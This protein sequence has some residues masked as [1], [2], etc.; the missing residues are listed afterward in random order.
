MRIF[1]LPIGVSWDN[2]QN[3]FNLS[4]HYILLYIWSYFMYI[5]WINFK[6]FNETSRFKNK[7]L[8]LIYSHMDYR[9][10]NLLNEI[11]VQSIPQI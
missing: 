6:N 7:N 5:Y 1:K 3:I 11:Y 2:N 9:Y 10:H 4:W 8:I